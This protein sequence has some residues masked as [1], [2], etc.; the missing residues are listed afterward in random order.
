M[1]KTARMRNHSA[2]SGSEARIR[3]DYIFKMRAKAV[4]SR[5][6]PRNV[7]DNLLIHGDLNAV[8]QGH[9]SSLAG[10]TRMAEPQN[11]RRIEGRRAARIHLFP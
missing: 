8:V 6:D 10:D 7:S 2:K 4:G 1:A 11:R 3:P 9:T 5:L